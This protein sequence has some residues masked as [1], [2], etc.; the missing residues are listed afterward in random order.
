M[1]LTINIKLFMLGV[2]FMVLNKLSS[3]AKKLNTFFKVLQRIIEITAIVTLCVL[4]VLTVANAINPNTVIG[5]GLNSLDIGFLSVTLSNA[6]TP[7]NGTIL[8]FAW[9]CTAFLLLF[10]IVL[11]R[12]LT[13]TRKILTPLEEGRPFHPDTAHDRKRLAFLSLILGVVQNLWTLIETS[14]TMHAY[15]LS[16]LMD[17]MGAGS[18]TVNYTLELGFIVVFFLFLLMSY[19]FSYGAELQTFSDET[20]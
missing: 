18:V 12:G 9:I 6:P 2:V 10:A 15:E 1:D 20:L 19:L 17:A 7:G 5:T 11:C 8:R 13:I 4:T 3:T 14:A 16:G